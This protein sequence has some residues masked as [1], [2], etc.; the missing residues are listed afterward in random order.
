MKKLRKCTIAKAVR[1]WNNVKNN[2]ELYN[3]FE[4]EIG[5]VF[6]ALVN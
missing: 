5:D 2:E 1:E 6:F 4:L 3:Q